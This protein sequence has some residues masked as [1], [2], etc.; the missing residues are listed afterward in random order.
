M[1]EN[2]KLNKK[3]QNKTNKS[4]NKLPKQIRLFYQT[5]YCCPLVECYAWLAYVECPKFA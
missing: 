2:K 5:W 4:K 1:E 3:K